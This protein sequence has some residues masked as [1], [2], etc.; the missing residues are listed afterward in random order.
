[1]KALG[2]SKPRV[3]ELLHT[4][5]QAFVALRAQGIPVTP[6]RL[7]GLELLPDWLLVRACQWALCTAFADLV[8]ARHATV[9]REEMAA[10][11]GQLRAL[12]AHSAGIAAK[13]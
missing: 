5:G 12:V 1:M 3:T 11:S 2:H 6:A 10:L 13:A 4:I 8:V 7:R 9:A